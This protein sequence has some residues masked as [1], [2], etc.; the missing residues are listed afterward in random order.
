MPQ[1]GRKAAN[2]L[3]PFAKGNRLA[4]KHLAYATF[5]PA[6]LEE[7]GALEEEI[8]AL[9]PVESPSI[10]PA[11][12]VLA[13]LLWRRA[14]LYAYVEAVGVTRGRADRATINPAFEALDRLE[15]QVIE[16]MRQLAMLPKVATDLGLSLVKLE[17]QRRFDRS[18]LTQAE[19]VELDRLLAKSATY[20]GELPDA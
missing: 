19:R 16:T 15:R 9:C 4:A 14:K 5:T 3:V 17:S 7:V 6:E 1:N 11:V 8:R 10:E 13:G 20:E 2:S 18:R 12:S